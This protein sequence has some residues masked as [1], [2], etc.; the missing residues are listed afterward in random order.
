[1][2]DSLRKNPKRSWLGLEDDINYWCSASTIRI[3]LTSRDSFKYYAERIFPNLL[4]HQKEK[5]AAFAYRL[6]N[7]WGRGGGKFLHIMFDEKWMWGLVVRR[8]AK[9]CSE[10]GLEKQ[11]YKAYHQNHIN[12][13]MMTAFTAVAF[14]DNFENGGEAVKLGIFRAQSYKVV[15]RE[16]RESVRQ[17]DGLSRQTGPIKRKA[18]GPG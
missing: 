1:M 12:K 13:V 4:P 14:E 16:V 8:Y 17:A 3:W 18:G 7:N 15:Y 5:H 2:I 9:S 10:A 11:F 6:R